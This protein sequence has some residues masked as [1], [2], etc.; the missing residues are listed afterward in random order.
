VFTIMVPAGTPLH[1]GQLAAVTLLLEH[2]AHVTA[3]R[4]TYYNEYKSALSYALSLRKS[5]ACQLLLQHSSAAITYAE[6]CS[7]VRPF[8]PPMIH[9]LLEADKERT[10]V[11]GWVG[12]QHHWQQ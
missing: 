10:H 6:L 9:L 2:G 5:E 3:E 4:G 7:A 8:N 11:G 1:H 12:G